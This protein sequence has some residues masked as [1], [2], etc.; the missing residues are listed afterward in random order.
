M[1]DDRGLPS[2]IS[3]DELDRLLDL[4]AGLRPAAIETIARGNSGKA[5]TLKRWLRAIDASEGFLDNS[6]RHRLQLAPGRVLARWRILGNLGQGGFSSVYRVERSDG[7]YEQ[8]GALK[9]L[10]SGQDAEHWQIAH[11]RRLLSRLNHP[12]I[13]RLLDGGVSKEGMSFLVTELIQGQSLQ[14]WLAAQQPDLK[15]R[16]RIMVQLCEAVAAAHAQLIVHGDLKPA[17]VLVDAQDQV[18]L[19]DFGVSRLIAAWGNQDAKQRAFTPAYAAPELLKGGSA[20][21][22]SDVF[23]LGLLLYW[24]LIG[25]LPPSRRTESTHDLLEQFDQEQIQAP[26]LDPDA[27]PIRPALRGELDAITLACLH[28]NPARRYANVQSLLFDLRAWQHG[29]PVSALPWTRTYLLRRFVSRHPWAVLGA[30]LLLVLIVGLVVDNLA[31]RRELQARLAP[32][33]PTL[34][35]PVPRTPAST[36]DLKPQSPTTRSASPVPGNTVPADPAAKSSG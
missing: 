6:G 28:P 10:R 20:S 5:A 30:S 18:H 31:L 3:E 32:P 22:S 12:N 26:S 35:M 15:R 13:A 29:M 33:L 25:Q 2:G 1:G 14:Q 19:I 34:K 17:N 7:A 23:A 4:P 36:T 11:E 9:V 27:V 24:L 21:T 16:M 8:L